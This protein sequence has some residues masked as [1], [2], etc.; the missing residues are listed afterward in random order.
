MRTPDTSDDL[1]VS[2][3][4]S[5]VNNWLDNQRLFG[6]DGGPS[7]FEVTYRRFGEIAR[8]NYPEEMPEFDPWS[9]VVNTTYLV[10]AAQRLN[11]G[12]QPSQPIPQVNFVAASPEARVVSSRSYDITFRTGSATFTPEAEDELRSVLDSATIAST[13][14]VEVHGHTD[15]TGDFNRNMTLSEERAFAVSRWLSQHASALFP[16][17]RIR[18]YAHGQTQPIDSNSTNEGRARNRRVEIVL[19]M[20]T[21]GH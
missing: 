20:A 17:G 4:G 16:E 11:L 2:L 6:L 1:T 5:Y 8:L 12:Q 13:L 3:G 21:A 9:D 18:V 7:A 10:R 14:S 19:R 15:N